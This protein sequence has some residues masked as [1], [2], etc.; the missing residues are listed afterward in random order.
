[1]WVILNIFKIITRSE[2]KG[3]FKR[4]ELQEG[5]KLEQKLDMMPPKPIFVEKN[6][7]LEFKNVLKNH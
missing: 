5:K 7:F 1:M 6:D 2:K 3:C 4:I